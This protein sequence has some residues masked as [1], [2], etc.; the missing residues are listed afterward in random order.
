MTIVRRLYASAFGVSKL[1]LAA[2]VLVG[3]SGVATAVASSPA[4]A[5]GAPTVGAG[6]GAFGNSPIVNLTGCTGTTSSE[7]L[8]C[9]SNPITAGVTVGMGAYGVDL[10]TTTPS[11]VT[12]VTATTIVLGTDPSATVTA[13]ATETFTGTQAIGGGT[14]ATAG[15]TVTSSGNFADYGVVPGLEVYGAGIP[16]Q[17]TVA[18]VSGT[19]MVLSQAPTAALSGTT[20]FFNAPD[21]NNVLTQVSGGASNVNTAS[22]TVVT[23]PPTADGYVTTSNTSTTGIVNMYQA[24]NPVDNSFSATLAYCAPGFTY[25][26]A[27]NC[28]TFTETYGIAQSQEMGEEIVEIIET[29]NIYEGDSQAHFGPTSAA[30][31]STVTLTE[32]PSGGAVPTTSSGAT[33]NYIDGDTYIM[34][35]PSGL[36]YVPGSVQLEGGDAQTSTSGAT[37]AT[38]CTAAG[39]GCTACNLAATS[40]CP[41]KDI[42]ANAYN[43]T[44]P[45]IEE[46]FGSATADEAKGGAL[47]TLPA[48]TASF[49]AT[50]PALSVQNQID[51]EYLVDT[52][53]TDVLNINVAFDGYPTAGQVAEPT[54]PP[55]V[56]PTPVASLTIDPA[57]TGTSTSNGN[58]DGADTGGQTVTITGSG[59]T[60]A[61]GEQVYFGT[62]PATSFTVNSNTSITAV[63]P[64]STTGDGPVDVTVVNEGLTTP[65]SPAD[66]FTYI[67]PT[68]PDFP[69]NV[70]PTSDNGQAEVSWTPGFNEGSPTQSYLVTATDVSSPSNDP[71]N[72][73]SGGETCT[74][75]VVTTDG[76]TD[77]CTV[78]GL[79]NGDQYTFSVT[80]TN[81]LGTSVPSPATTAITIGDPGPPTGVSATAAQNANS[82][83]SW[84]DPANSGSG[85]AALRD[86]DGSR[87]LAPVQP[88][89]RCPVHLLRTGEPELQRGR[90]GRPVQHRRADQR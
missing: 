25:P 87:H 19:S 78:P 57:V 62:N 61:G 49:T 10:N 35:V 36:T 53:V 8:T 39:P 64:A 58:D 2:L 66:Q 40:T 52:N 37:T 47:H 3:V 81:G 85:R 31:G 30:Q 63:A 55:P 69:L 5:A 79:T 20:L 41:T 71:N 88:E 15:T 43:T 23:Q 51:T 18:T 21:V 46:Q 13:A 24:L 70:V 68:A 9:T 89:Q 22:L 16:A 84:A 11:S 83:I 90:P 38:Y 6:Y 82:T 60:N 54:E 27:G 65:T 80:A 48:I 28:T 73:G 75:T 7:T 33:V 42:P 29:E 14:D 34:P 50:G 72:G 45:Y 26:S 76:P 56:A 4:F 59:F 74:Y 1:V 67:P 86:G 77:T 12:S 17:T 32:A 44:Y